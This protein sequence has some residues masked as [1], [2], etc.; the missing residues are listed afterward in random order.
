MIRYIVPLILVYLAYRL[1]KRWIRDKMISGRMNGSGV[2]RIDD[3]M[4]KDPQCG[5]YFPQ[6]DGVA[7]RSE[8]RDL[9]FCSQKCRDSYIAAHS[10][11][12][13]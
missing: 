4:V 1:V 5:A 6:R 3:V 2:D 12:G 8:G 13:D 9:L 7:L 11:S 10:P